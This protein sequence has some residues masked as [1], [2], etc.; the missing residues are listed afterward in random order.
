MSSRHRRSSGT[1]GDVALRRLVPA[2]WRGMA[3]CRW[4]VGPDE[5]V[6]KFPAGT[7]VCLGHRSALVV[8]SGQWTAGYLALRVG[9]RL[10]IWWAWSERAAGSRRYM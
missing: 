7:F 5:M 8:R 2:A 3:T 1:A 10:N 4:D 6:A 9:R